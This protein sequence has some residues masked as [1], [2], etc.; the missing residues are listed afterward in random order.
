[1]LG[2]AVA[3]ARNAR[4]RREEEQIQAL[5]KRHV[6]LQRMNKVEKVYKEMES[7]KVCMCLF[8][9]DFVSIAASL[10]AGALPRVQESLSVF[11]ITDLCS[12]SWLLKVLFVS[13]P[14]HFVRACKGFVTI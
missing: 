4:E 1:M 13:L 5:F 10:W 7:R 12:H 14:A 11:K 9:S 6:L 2:A 3:A 8:E